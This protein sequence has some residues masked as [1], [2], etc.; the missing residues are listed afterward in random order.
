[1][2]Q[3]LPLLAAA[4]DPDAETHQDDPAGSSDACDKRRLLDHICN[5]FS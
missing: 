2:A 1:M 3:L 4:V 5:L